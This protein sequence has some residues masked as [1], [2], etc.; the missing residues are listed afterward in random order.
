MLTTGADGKVKLAGGVVEVA[1][2]NE[3]PTGLD[4]GTYWLIETGAPEGYL[5]RDE[6]FPIGITVGEDGVPTLVLD[7]A[8]DTA[9]SKTLPTLSGPDNDG[10]YQLVVPNA[11]L[12]TLPSAGGPGSTLFLLG[13]A[14][15][16]G[17]AVV[18]MRDERK[19]A[20]QQ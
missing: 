10:V 20:L 9:T 11:R 8:Y 1:G 18:F 14:F 19:L 15:A 17:L 13:G 2:G 4:S 3:V 12:Y 6:K 16:A 7:E 5:V